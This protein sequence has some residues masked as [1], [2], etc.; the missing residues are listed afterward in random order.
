LDS[1]FVYTK[2]REHFENEVMVEL[3]TQG[4]RIAGIVGLKQG[5]V[6][7]CA[8]CYTWEDTVCND[9]DKYGPGIIC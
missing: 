9:H 3:I 8:N 4:K 7:F 1:G 5:K 2:E 6:H